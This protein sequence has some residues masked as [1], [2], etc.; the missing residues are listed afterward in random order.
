MKEIHRAFYNALLGLVYKKKYPTTHRNYES[1]FK[2]GLGLGLN[3][4][5]FMYGVHVENTFS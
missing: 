4:E 5:L 1:N 2:I 3:N